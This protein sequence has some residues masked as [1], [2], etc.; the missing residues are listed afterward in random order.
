M[1]QAELRKQPGD[2]A[3]K[4]PHSVNASIPT[5]S[6]LPI[7]STFLMDL[8]RVHKTPGGLR[9]TAYIEPFKVYSIRLLRRT[10]TNEIGAAQAAR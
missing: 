2:I 9:R 1:T 4:P 5:T 3:A 10:P 8:N 7:G 6:L